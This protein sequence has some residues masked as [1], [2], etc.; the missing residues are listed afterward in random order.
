MDSIVYTWL[1]I[2]STKKNQTKNQWINEFSVLDTKL[3][4]QSRKKC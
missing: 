2:N 1:I 3:S 4:V